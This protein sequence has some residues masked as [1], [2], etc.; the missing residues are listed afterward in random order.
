MLPRSLLKRLQQLSFFDTFK[1]AS[2]Y[3][4]GTLLVQALG[5]ITLPIFTE[6][7]EPSEYGI[8]NVF[9]SYLM[10]FAVV[11]SLNLFAGAGRYF[12]ETD[13]ADF[14]AFMGTITLAS[15]VVFMIQASLMLY[16]ESQLATWMNLPVHLIK[17]LIGTTFF[18]IVINT[19]FQ[20]LVV[21]EK[22]KI[23]STVL[24]IWQYSKFGLTVAGLILLT[25]DLYYT[26][27]GWQSYTFMGKIVGEFIGTVVVACYA[28]WQLR[29]YISFHN[30][31]WKHLNYS[32]RFSLPLLPIALSGYLLV[33]FDQWF[34]NSS[35]G[36]TEAGQYAFAYKLGLLYFGLIS[37][38]TSGANAKYYTFMNEKAYG[39]VARQVESMTKLL[40]LGGC[41]LMFFAVDIGTLL[42][43]K[44]SY[45]NALPVAPIIVG[46][47]VIH[48]IGIIYNRG[49]YFVKKNVYLT[50]VV[51]ISAFLNIALNM[52]YIPQYGYLAAAYTT[53][54]SYVFSVVLTIVITDYVLK[55]PRLPLGRIL[56]YL[57]LLASVVAINYQFGEPDI[58]LHLGWMCFKG[59]LFAVM[60]TVLFYNQIKLF[61]TN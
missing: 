12:F 25:G 46:G 31:S 40:M 59:G 51:F 29:N 22:S 37:A 38:L 36:Q 61:F 4:S 17:W 1:H 21:T 11:L 13:K 16:Y 15:V 28:G 39:E 58:G 48:G 60:G 9:T 19:F 6:F 32:L 47:Y 56:K 41:F 52:Y 5:V 14:P 2:T 10:T 49:I 44:D 18:L 45:L 57:V 23:Y 7:L 43:S 27:D 20:I 42:T 50:F 8:I 34:I 54:F 26:T 3:F 24:V 30:L 53:F 33:S 35:V 55:L